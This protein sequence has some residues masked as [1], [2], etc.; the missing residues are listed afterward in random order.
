MSNRLDEFFA[1]FE[2]G[3]LVFHDA[4]NSRYSGVV[5]VVLKVYDRGLYKVFFPTKQGHKFPR[6]HQSFLKKI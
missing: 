4:L 5:G 6:L 1:P 3:D 2:V